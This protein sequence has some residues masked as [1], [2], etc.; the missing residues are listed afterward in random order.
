MR[1]LNLVVGLEGLE[2]LRRV[3]EGIHLW[4]GSIGAV[5]LGKV[6]VTCW[7]QLQSAQIHVTCQGMSLC[8]V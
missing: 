2:S 1:N 3:G 4:G 7:R 5:E 6:E 8:V